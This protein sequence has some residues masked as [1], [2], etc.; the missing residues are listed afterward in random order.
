MR[1]GVCILPTDAWPTAVAQVR[2]VEELG[3]GHLWTYDHLSWRHYRER[4]WFAAVPWLTGMAA[5]TERIRIGTLVANPNFREPLTL[6]RDAIAIDHVSDG[7]F[8]LGVG[9]GGTGFDAT[10]YGAELGAAARTA[11]FAEMVKALDGLLDGARSFRGAHYTVDDARTLPGS[12]QR[13]RL[14]LAIAAEGPKALALAARY[15][16]AWITH[17]VDTTGVPDPFADL[18]D[19]VH[20]FDDEIVAADRDPATIARIHL[21]GFG[22]LR[23]LASRTAFLDYAGRCAEAGVTDLI[24]HHPRA[25]DPARNDPPDILEQ[26]AD[27]DLT[28]VHAL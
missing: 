5:L 8:I 10:V 24:V 1:V 3:F 27:E 2:R 7:R 13:P 28:T 19:R 25:D 12:R 21:S 16:D 9:S 18:R 4:P 14:P 26:I 6:A 22:G 17:G 20:R 15:G 11:R 23:P